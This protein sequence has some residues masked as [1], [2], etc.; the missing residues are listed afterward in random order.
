MEQ[1]DFFDE[2]F[3]KKLYRMQKWMAKIQ[4]QVNLF[5]EEIS[6]LQIVVNSSKKKIKIDK[7]HPK[8]EQGDM[9]GT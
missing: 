6:F 4:Q 1:L 9:F 5:N 7:A 8:L 3:L 2:T